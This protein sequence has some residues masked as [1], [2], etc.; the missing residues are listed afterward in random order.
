M[1]NNSL[2]Y[3]HAVCFCF[4]AS[5]LLYACFQKSKIGPPKTPKQRLQKQEF[6]KESVLPVGWVHLLN[7]V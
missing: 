7:T 2:M 1:V 6:I 4:T 3:Q 5:Y